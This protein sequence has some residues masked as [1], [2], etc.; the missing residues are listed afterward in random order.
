[1]NRFDFQTH[2]TASD[3]RH[4]PA[5]VA[6]MA[7]EH[8][9]DAIAITD[10]DTVAGLEEA[11]KAGEKFGVRVIPGIEISA[12][13]KGAHLLGYG[14]DRFNSPL[15]DAL[16]LSR[17]SRIE[18]A[19][20]I[21]ENLKNAGFIVEWEDVLREAA[22]ASVI[23]RPHLARAVIG[24]VE[25]KEKIQGISSPH[26]FI[27]KYLTNESP[28]YVHRAHIS[29]RD[30]INLIHGAGGAAVWSHPILEF[31]RKPD[32][33]EVFLKKLIEWGLD[34]MEVFNP[35]H[36][37]DDAEMIEGLCRKYGMCRSAGS[38]FHEQ[39]E[40]PADSI[41]GLHS[42][43]FPGDYETYGFSV[44]DILFRLEEAMAKYALR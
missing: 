23:A 44:D 36:T 40:H 22:T 43:R 10:H 32:G 35:S 30:A 15:R 11:L 13:E 12:E 14:I 26:D 33:L 21:V 38:D 31:R 5:E 41:T 17:K 20:R 16:E 3:G 29:G 8:G 25:N 9:L 39:G 24:R 19:E 28:L 18:G 27:E 6:A 42:A 37:E 2:T 34:G 1:M 4:S 7:K